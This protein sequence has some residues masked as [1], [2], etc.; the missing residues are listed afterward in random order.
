MGYE[1]KD[2]RTRVDL[3]PRQVFQ[4]CSRHDPPN[5]AS[6]PNSSSEPPK[7]NPQFVEMLMGMPFYWTALTGSEP[8]E[9]EWSHYTRLLRSEF[10]RLVQD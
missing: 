4:A 6:G 5:W 8:S 7:L 2:G 3:L 10:S 1:R 9:T